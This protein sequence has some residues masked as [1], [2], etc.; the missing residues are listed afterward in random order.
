MSNNAAAAVV[1]VFKYRLLLADN[2]RQKFAD[3]ISTLEQSNVEVAYTNDKNKIT[4]LAAQFKPDIVVMNLFLGTATTVPIIREL[5]RV[6]LKQNSKILVLTTH[7]S[8]ENIAECIR[9]GASDFI[10]EPFDSKL[11]IQRIRYQLQDKEFIAPE[12]IRAEPTQVA[13]GFQLIYECLKLLSEI[14]DTHR[15]IFEVIK[16]VGELVKSQ[17]VNVILGDF[18]TG[19]GEIAAAS[20]D[21]NL[22]HK[23]TDLEK[24]P[25]VREVLLNNSIVYIK[26]ITQNP[27]TQGIKDNVKSIDIASLLVFPI[28][29]RQETIGTLNIRLGKDGMNVSDK[30]LKTFYMVA[31]AIASKVA[32]KKLMKRLQPPPPPT[33]T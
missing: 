23:A 24:Y 14:K 3:V 4:E 27:L 12:D 16:R 30:H 33:Q 31:L 9:S 15:A 29:H 32:A 19:V 21:V 22:A 1:P 20:D 10:L 26:D 2:S 7:Y 17:R 5:R 28:R 8:K 25:E 11:L 6:L 18:E 13:A